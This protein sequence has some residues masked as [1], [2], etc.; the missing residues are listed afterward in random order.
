MKMKHG[1]QKVYEVKFDA[2]SI[3]MGLINSHFFA[4]NIPKEQLA[5]YKKG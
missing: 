5:N 4:Y 3:V 2:G 1:I